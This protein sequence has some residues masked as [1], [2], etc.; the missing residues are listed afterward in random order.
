MPLT[1]HT[2]SGLAPSWLYFCPTPG[3]HFLSVIA[4]RT[5]QIDTDGGLTPIGEDDQPPAI[6]DLFR[7]DE[8][9]APL[10]YPSDIV[11][12]KAKA[13]LTLTG[14][15]YAPA[16][17]PCKVLDV[18]FGLE[19]APRRLRIV[20]DRVRGVDAL[21]RPTATEPMPFASMPLAYDRAY[22]GPGFHQNPAGCGFVPGGMDPAA[23]QGLPLP[24][25]LD[26]AHDHAGAFDQPSVVGFGPLNPHWSGRRAF[27]GTYEA[28]YAE[29]LWPCFAADFDWEYFNAA[30]EAQRFPKPL[31]G[32]EVVVARNLNADNPAMRIVLPAWRSR[33]FALVSSQPDEAPTL[34]EV[35][36]ALDTVHV[37]L[38]AM[39]LSL[40]WRGHFEV[41]SSRYPEVQ[42]IY[43]ARED[44]A[45]DPLSAQTYRDRL[46]AIIEAENPPPP[47]PMPP[48]PEEEDS[49]LASKVEES[50]DADLRAEMDEMLAALKSQ[51]HPDAVP[52]E[53]YRELIDERDLDRFADRLRAALPDRSEEFKAAEQAAREKL[54]ADFIAQGLDPSIL[55]LEDEP[56][57][58]EDATA[59]A[60]DDSGWTR[61]RV[62][63]AHRSGE[64]LDGLD[65]SG[66]D[67]SNLPLDGASMKQS[68]LSRCRLTQSSL[69]GADLTGAYLDGAELIETD[70]SSA[71]LEGA[72]LSTV[73][74]DRAAFRSA[75][76]AGADLSEAILASC[77]FA[78]ADLTGCLLVGAD[79]RMADFTGATAKSATFAGA[80]LEAARFVRCNL[81]EASI[82]QCQGGQADFSGAD[83]ERVRAAECRLPG[84]KFTEVSGNYASFPN[85]QLDGADFSFADLVRAD[86]SGCSLVRASL[87]AVDFTTG[88]ATDADLRGTRIRSAKLFM[89]TFERARLVGADLRGACLFRAELLDA[90]IDGVNWL[91]ADLGGTRI[92]GRVDTTREQ[93]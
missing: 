51:L 14:A 6:G 17:S 82:E 68:I 39:L 28:D 69:V 72:D 21:G 49:T 59:E 40:V 32:D 31:A 78:G 52:P 70:F 1:F 86:L 84:A 42:R 10:L 73:R 74:A 12:F 76:L 54:K 9:T 83:C 90:E 3:R 13:D 30:P 16:G 56:D 62:Y 79:L 24:N 35:G 61:E 92:D 66:L 87:D 18:E 23:V 65:L 47:P 57:V 85:S 64:A 15:A 50:D 29:T 55:D 22:G 67:L 60:T 80:L 5:F 75:T 11:P 91:N 20:G 63:A 2:E 25:L 41:S 4:K 44:L 38:D 43:L 89:A 8:P 37:D 7:D 36:L 93:P 34:S 81:A 19:S 88:M 26:P 33:A 46:A 77:S 27:L 53:V 71:T 45:A 58:Q 48:S